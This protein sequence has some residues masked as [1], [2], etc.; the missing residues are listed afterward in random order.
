MGLTRQR[1]TIQ[2]R[3]AAQEKGVEKDYGGRRTPGSGSGW[4]KRGDVETDRFLFECKSTENKT[5]ITIRHRDVLQVKQR[6]AASGRVPVLTF[7]IDGSR[8]HI[9][10]DADFQEL[11]GGGD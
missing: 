11:V 3:S 2:R 8:Y 5:Q 7:D 6:A 4:R 10:A 9:L 1:K